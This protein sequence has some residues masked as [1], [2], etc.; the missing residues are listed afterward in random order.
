MLPFREAQTIE[1]L[2]DLLYDF[3]PGSGNNKTAFPVAAQQA[4]VAEFWQAGSKRPAIVQ[5]LSAT[6]E[7]P[8]PEGDCVFPSVPLRELLKPD[9]RKK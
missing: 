2:A 6:R 5:L 4:G 9:G 7:R 3:L 8:P 1:D